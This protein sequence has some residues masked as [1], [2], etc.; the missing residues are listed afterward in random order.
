MTDTIARTFT[1]GGKYRVVAPRRYSESVTPRVDEGDIVTTESGFIDHD[2]EVSITDE[3][4]RYSYVMTDCLVELE[5]DAR[6]LKVGDRVIVPATATSNNGSGGV[7]FG[8]AGRP[9]R[10]SIEGEITQLNPH[11]P[12]SSE[13]RALTGDAIGTTQYVDKKCLTL[14][15]SKPSAFPITH[16]TPSRDELTEAVARADV[17][18]KALAD[19]R[20]L[21]RRSVI[22]EAAERDWCGE[23]D[24]WL[25]TLGLG[26]VLP[27]D[28]PRDRHAVVLLTDGRVAIRKDDDDEPWRVYEASGNVSYINGDSWCSDRQVGALYSSTLSSG[29]SD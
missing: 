4:G 11:G 15:T 23:V 22:A 24:G 7:Y 19:F 6:E 17:A 21:V 20:E 26:T 2:G 9:A 1:A 10:E 18:E 5:P 13:V 27:E 29:V 8:G 12:H 14:V 25:D 16:E 3:H 28:F